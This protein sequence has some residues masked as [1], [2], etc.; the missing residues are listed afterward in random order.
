MGTSTPPCLSEDIPVATWVG[1]LAG[2]E[3]FL[4]LSVGYGST[5]GTRVGVCG[6]PTGTHTLI[7]WLMLS[8]VRVLYDAL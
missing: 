7:P 4:S 1:E 8:H 3:D 5:N 2:G 6:S